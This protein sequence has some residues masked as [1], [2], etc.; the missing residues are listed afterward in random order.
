MMIKERLGR[1]E[2]GAV[3]FAIK[4]NGREYRPG[5]PEDWQMADVAKKE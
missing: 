3:G 5:L 2:N 1:L 4:D